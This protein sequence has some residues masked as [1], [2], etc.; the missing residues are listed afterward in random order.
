MTSSVH[1]HVILEHAIEAGGRLPLADLEGWAAATHGAGAA[2]HTCSAEGMNFTALI[3]FLAGRNKVT[4][5]DGQLTVLVENVCR[6]DEGD[7]HH[8]HPS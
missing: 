6:H 8:H 4:V 5:S 2:Y 1:G 7:G 3:A